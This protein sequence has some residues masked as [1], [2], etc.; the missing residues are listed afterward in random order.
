[1]VVASFGAFVEFKTDIC[2]SLQLPVVSF[3]VTP[4]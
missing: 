3:L 1:M 2:V 4:C